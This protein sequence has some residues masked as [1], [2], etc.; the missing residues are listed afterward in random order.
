M[1]EDIKKIKS[2]HDISPREYM[3]FP[4]GTIELGK[5]GQFSNLEITHLLISIFVLTFAFSFALTG[6]NIIQVYFNG[7]KL[8]NLLLGVGKSFLGVVIAFFG[9]EISHKFMAQ[10]FHL[11]SEYRMYTRGLILAGILGFFTPIVFAAPGAV[12]FRGKVRIF[13]MGK[14]AFAGPLANIFI[15]FISFLLYRFIFFELPLL[16]EIF[17]FICLINSVL[18]VFNLIPFK[19]FDGYKII[20]WNANIWLITFI[21]SSLILILIITNI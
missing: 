13:E 1:V 9:H 19:K 20:N 17:G 14:I 16:N 5:P 8:D 15:A 7:F 12:M 21:I 4:K 2:Y 11:W 6:N 3:Y 18:A 10:K